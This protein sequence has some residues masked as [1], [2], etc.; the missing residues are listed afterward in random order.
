MTMVFLQQPLALPG[1]A[2]KWIGC[3][4]RSGLPEIPT[5]IM[6]FPWGLEETMHA[7]RF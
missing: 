3:T 2:S 6:T 4:L 1:S 7:N 5:M